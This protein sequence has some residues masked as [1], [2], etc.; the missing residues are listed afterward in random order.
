MS[1]QK[2]EKELRAKG[3]RKI[4]NSTKKLNASELRLTVGV[5]FIKKMN[6]SGLR[7]PK[8]H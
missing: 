5:V 7:R 8:R 2:S 4:W 6:D 3:S 1:R